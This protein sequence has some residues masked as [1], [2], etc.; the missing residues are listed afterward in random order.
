MT[1]TY[2][3]NRLGA[4]ALSVLVTLLPACTTEPN[5]SASSNQSD[6]I[7]LSEASEPQRIVALTTLTADI[8]HQLDETALIGIPGS[9]LL[10]DNPRFDGLE[11]VSGGRTPPNLEKI[12]ALDP[13]LV[14]GAR[15]FHEQV[16]EQL[17]PLGIPTLLTEVNNWESLRSLT[18]EL[19]EVIGADETPLLQR[20]DQCLARAAEQDHSLIVLVSYQPI[21]APNQNSW[22]GDFIQRFNFQ[23]LMADPQSDSGLIPSEAFQGYLSFSAERLLQDD[24]DFLFVVN[25]EDDILEQF[26]SKSFWSALKA[27]QSNNVYVFDYYGLVNPGTL[28]SIEETCEQLANVSDMP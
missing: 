17:E 5:D 9:R 26:A 2:L 12:I 18:I 23:N 22:A 25:T 4:I 19:A 27:T 15:G 3:N 7:A 11:I 14:V 24:P 13:T 10:A 16:V 6:T 20:Y 28:E 8:T 21:L 1:M